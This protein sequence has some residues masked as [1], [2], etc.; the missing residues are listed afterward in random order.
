MKQ[1]FDDTKLTWG[2]KRTGAGRPSSG[3]SKK[4]IYVTD[5]EFELLKNLL[6]VYRQGDQL[7]YSIA[8]AQKAA[9]LIIAKKNEAFFK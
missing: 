5:Y 6:E 4:N 9:D 3:R 8:D 2:G 1:I 7:K